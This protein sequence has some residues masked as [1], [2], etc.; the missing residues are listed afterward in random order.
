MEKRKEFAWKESE[1]L[2]NRTTKER[3][4]VVSIVL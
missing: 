2:S 4:E 3:K 1:V